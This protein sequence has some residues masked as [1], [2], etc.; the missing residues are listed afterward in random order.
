MA[1]TGREI[2][3]R[4]TRALA[5]RDWSTAASLLADDFIEDYPQS[6]ER[7]VGRQNLLAI[8][9]NYPGEIVAGA[10]APEVEGVGATERWVMTPAFT[11]LRVEG[12]EGR[13]TTITSA[14]YPDRSEWYIVGRLTL[15]GD[16]IVRAGTF[17]APA[18]PAPEWRRP[19]VT[20]T[21]DT[22]EQVSA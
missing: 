9:E 21:S 17:F 4:Y 13:Y 8:V 14:I 6:G 16:R 10:S 1:E 22:D 7:I 19:Y 3:E 15:R 5:A 11:T 12:S 18:F 2:V 20:Q